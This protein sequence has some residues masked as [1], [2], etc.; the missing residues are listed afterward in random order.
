[1]ARLSTPEGVGVFYN[2]YTFPVEVEPLRV[3]VTPNYDSAGRVVVSTTHSY[4][5]KAK[6]LATSA[7]GQSTTSNFLEEVR[8]LL[9]QPGG[10]LTITGMGFGDLTVNDTDGGGVRDVAWGPKPRLLSC[11]Q[12]GRDM[13]WEITWKVEVCILDQCASGR[14]RDSIMEFCYRLAVS[15]DRSGYTQRTYSGHLRIPQSKTTAGSRTLTDNADRYL[16]S[17]IPKI[18]QGFRRDTTQRE[19]SEDKCSLSFTVTDSELRGFAPPPD[20]V[21]SEVRQTLA[22]AGPSKFLQWTTTLR[23]RYELAK[24]VPKARAWGL[25]FK[26]LEERMRHTKKLAQ[27][28]K[29]VIPLTLHISG[30]DLH[31]AEAGDFTFTYSY[32]M[33]RKELRRAVEAAGIWLPP[34]EGNDPA[35]WAR[36]LQAHGA[37]TPRGYAY[38]QFLN[39]DDLLVDLCDSS[40]PRPAPM[41]Q[42]GNKLV[43]KEFDADTD[44]R[45]DTNP[46]NMARPAPSKSWIDFRHRIIISEIDNTAVH[47]PLPAQAVQYTPPAGSI[48]RQDGFRTGYNRG[49]APIIQRRGSPLMFATIVGQGARVGYP[50]TPPVLS[51]VG[52]VPAYPLNDGRDTYRTEVISNIGQPVIGALWSRRY[53]LGGIPQVGILPPD[54]IFFGNTQ[55]DRLEGF[56]VQG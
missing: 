35:A 31:G 3:E 49:V 38:L 44:E 22:N 19:I 26:L 43:R 41:R 20:V 50:I 32:V 48:D 24:G 15:V 56:T 10:M 9:T 1:M 14:Y 30:G 33:D 29:S 7:S 39:T 46:F 13:A 8:F 36:A 18:P 17:A 5:F 54:H 27:S 55:D 40:P 45:D 25:F 6:I 28:P 37:S 11:V 4:V 47:Q 12:L 51:S 23:G 34:P 16:E 21:L 53:V 2:G 52:G 42:A